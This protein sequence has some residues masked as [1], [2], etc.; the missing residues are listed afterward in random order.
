M[1]K[2]SDDDL[3]R[4][5]AMSAQGSQAAA[6]V[7]ASAPA[8]P[9]ADIA[10]NRG[11]I[12][13]WLGGID[14]NMRSCSGSTCSSVII[15]PKDGKVRVDTATIRSVTETSGAETPWVRVTYEGA[16][17]T[18]TDINKTTNC[19]PSQGTE[20]PMTGWMNYTRLLPSPRTP[21]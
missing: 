2:V 14:M 13:M 11:V 12:D 3:N 20:A 17:C 15:V 18:A 21:Q 1:R 10:T 5:S 8:A 16:Y 4:I 7:P 19:T 6:Q 9:V